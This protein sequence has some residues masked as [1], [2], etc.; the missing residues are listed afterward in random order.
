MARPL[1][2]S[3]TKKQAGLLRP[4]SVIFRKSAFLSGRI[5]PQLFFH[6]NAVLI[7]AVHQPGQRPEPRFHKETI[8]RAY[9]P[10]IAMLQHILIRIHLFRAME[11]GGAQ[12]DHL[13]AEFSRQVQREVL[14]VR[15]EVRSGNS[16][17]P[18][19]ATD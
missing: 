15:A 7:I 5:F 18:L 4:V 2:L 14:M 1:D 8:D 11:L 3:K 13:T 12:S 17:G 6:S 9:L 16:G 10:L 19:L